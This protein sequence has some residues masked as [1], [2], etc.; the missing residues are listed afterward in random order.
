VLEAMR[1]DCA[2]ARE[3]LAE[4][5]RTIEE[6]GL[7]LWA[8]VNAQEAYLVESL[9]GT[10]GAAIETLRESFAT[11]D[12]AGERGFLSTIAGFLAHALLADGHDAEADRFS[13]E[14]EAA[15]APADVLSQVLWR[16]AKAKL[17]ARQ[18]LLNEAKALTREAVRLSEPTDLLGTRA[19]ALADL[20]DVLELAG[21]EDEALAALLEAARLYESKGNLTALGRVRSHAERLQATG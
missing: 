5:R 7:T 18:G 16:T 2:L 9:A 20:A 4:G 12:D 21:R 17:R 15:A 1:G 10:P 19:A 13:R 6:A 8:A 11:L 14:S 3:L